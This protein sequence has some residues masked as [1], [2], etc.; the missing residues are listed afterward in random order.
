[1]SFY[2]RLWRRGSGLPSFLAFVCMAAWICTGCGKATTPEQTGTPGKH[3]HVAPNG[4]TPVAL[5]ED[6]YHLELVLDAAAGTMQAYVLDGEMEGYV[7]VAAPS[8]EVVAKQT[9]GDVGL[10]FAAVANRATGETV[11]YT[12]QFAAQADWLKTV[13]TF[14]GVLKVLT[15]KG[16]VFKN[17]A[18][19]FPKGNE[20]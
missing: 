7:R 6:D 5:G 4:G 8:F 1:M 3:Q 19:N 13:K 11:G 20:K 17:V 2:T 10:V 18:F 15:V 12:S 9:N 14:D 16:K